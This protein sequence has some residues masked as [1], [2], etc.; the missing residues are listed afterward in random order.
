MLPQNI[1]SRE[2]GPRRR[3]PSSSEPDLYFYHPPNFSTVSKFP[4]GPQGKTRAEVIE[5]YFCPL[6]FQH[7]M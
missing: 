2:N 5:K 7:K 3:F 1:W 4:F 6:S